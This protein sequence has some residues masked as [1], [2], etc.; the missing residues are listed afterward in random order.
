[1]CNLHHKHVMKRL[2]RIVGYIKPYT[3]YV[4]LNILFNILSSLFALFSFTMVIPFLTI[5][6]QSELPSSEVPSGF[7][8]TADYL[9]QVLN[10]LLAQ[11]IGIKGKEHAL[12]IISIFVVIM[13]LLKNLFK[14]MA[15]Y[16]M[17]PI[18]T[19]VIR[20]IRNKM[21]DKVI[22]L[23][24][25]YY[26]DTRKGD[27][28][29]RMS[30]DVMEVEVS[31]MS[32]L[33]MLV[34]DPFTIVIFLLYMFTSSVQLTLF[35]IVLLPASGWLI[36]KIGRSLRA[37]SLKGQKKLGMIIS[38]IEETI[39][40]LRIIKAFNGEY[41][42]TR[43][44]L[45]VN[46][47]YTRIMNRVHR[48]KY[49]ASPASEFLATLVMMILMWYGGT[50]VLRGT[51]GLS[52]EAF[53]AYLVVF[54]QIIT[55]AKA[56]SGAYFNIQKGLA[57]AERIDQILEAEVTIKDCENPRPIKEF[58]SYIEFRNVSFRYDRDLVL[59][60]IHLKILK[61]QTVALVGKSGAGKTTLVDLIPRFIDVTEGE[62]L[63]DGHPIVEYKLH[64]L[65]N[66]MGI[67]TQH[68]IL[69]ND[70]FYNNIAFG[71]SN[72]VEEDVYNAAKAANAHDFI[73][74]TPEG[75]FTNIGEGGSK[76]SGGQ[77]QRISIARALL[78]NPPILILDEATS[79]L[80]TESERLVQDAINHLMKNRTSIVIAHRLSTIK[81]ADQI[82]VIDDGQIVEYGSHHDLIAM[83]GLYN[84]LHDLQIK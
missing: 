60:N 25:S 8:P 16:F 30:T 53:I 83:N 40:G 18:R 82:C 32:S 38:L 29:S 81:N 28:I 45:T 35:A 55:P 33:E 24:L 46:Q 34:T 84:R 4:V 7:Q 59:K 43:K 78:I 64:D 19:G 14:F 21:Y 15:N 11:L 72:A 77:R 80:D 31:I 27:V 57:S 22:R 20:D 68:P 5:L 79:S 12:L 67:V 62:L 47:M 50:L 63:I 69:F 56:I 71:V 10:Y 51:G 52:S 65:R 54:S 23:P 58:R 74:E 49:L 3:H 75:Y 6:F 73:M 39:S 17:A 36:G 13:F 42:V 9:N 44:F 66:L 61:G 26:T 37:T 41:K 70:T 48:K 2:F 1:M 76:L